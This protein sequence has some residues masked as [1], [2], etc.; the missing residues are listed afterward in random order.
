[1]CICMVAWDRVNPAAEELM[2]SCSGSDLLWSG[3]AENWAFGFVE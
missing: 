2:G 1:M 3:R